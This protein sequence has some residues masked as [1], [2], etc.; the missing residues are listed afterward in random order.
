AKSIGPANGFY[1]SRWSEW[2]VNQSLDAVVN[3]DFD[4]DGRSNVIGLFN[5]T[6][7]WYGQSN[8]RMFQMQFWLDWTA[9]AGGLLTLDVGHTNK[10]ALAD[11]IARDANHQWI[12][13]ESTGTG[14]SEAE[15][16]QW[17]NVTWDHVHVGQ[18][19]GT[20]Q[21]AAETPLPTSI[22]LFQ[23]T[24]DRS[25]E[26]TDRWSGRWTL[27]Q[28]LGS[29]LVNQPATQLNQAMSPEESLEL[30]SVADYK[31]FG[32]PELLAYLSG[33]SY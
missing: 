7:L 4:G 21:I 27:Q 12:A 26:E 33:S 2:T 29:S 24:E 18:F 8:G 3:G 1:S 23:T 10:D 25:Y 14:F 22:P 20:I 11:L 32:A 31:E 6:K 5:G 17:S 16:V 13:A 28:E 9:A 30:N 19:T 15:L